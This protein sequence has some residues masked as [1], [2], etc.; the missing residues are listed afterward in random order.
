MAHKAD[1][2]FKNYNWGVIFPDARGCC[3]GREWKSIAF[4]NLSRIQ[5]IKTVPLTNHVTEAQLDLF[6]QKTQVSLAFFFVNSLKE[7]TIM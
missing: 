2:H 3:T 7:I 1:Y 5:T 4:L 6:I